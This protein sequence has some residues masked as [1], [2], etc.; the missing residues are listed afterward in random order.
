MVAEESAQSGGEHGEAPESGQSPAGGGFQAAIH[1]EGPAAIKSVAGMRPGEID[2]VVDGVAQDDGIGIE[3]EKEFALGMARGLVVSTGKPQIGAGD[4]EL[5]MWKFLADNGSG[6]V[7]G[8]V[9][10]DNDLLRDMI[11]LVE[12]ALQTTA[13]VFFRV[14]AD[15][16]DGDVG[17]H[18]GEGGGGRHKS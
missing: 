16:D 3:K 17:G 2:D 18:E 10:Q 5:H 6:T 12:N 13:D 15:D 14:V 8:V 1:L 7:A 4:Y 9:I 11:A